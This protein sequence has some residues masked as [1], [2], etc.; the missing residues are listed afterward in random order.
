[1][2]KI[3]ATIFLSIAAGIHAA[4][5][6]AWKDSPNESYLPRRTIRELTIALGIGIILSLFH[7]WQSE[8]YFIIYLSTYTLARFVTEFY[9]L[10]I[11]VEP[12]ENYRIP[13]QIHFLGKVVQS[14]IRR[15]LFGLLPV[16]IVT[17][18]YLVARS[19]PDSLNVQLRGVIVGLLI[20]LADASGG[21]YKDGL[22]EGMVTPKIKT[23]NRP[24]YHPI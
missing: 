23:K 3:I 4:S 21:A 9:K 1:M 20:G 22:I 14:R 2:A 15:I 12:Q 7:I 24:K 10:F 8:N 13:T 6:G 11:R 19:L 17:S 5:Y 16:M 18:V